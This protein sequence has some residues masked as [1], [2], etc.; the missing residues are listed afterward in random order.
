MTLA[1]EHAL[2][3]PSHATSPA[4]RRWELSIVAPLIGLVLFF[5]AWQ[6]VVIIFGVKEFELPRPT[7]IFRH[8]FSDLGFYERNARTTLWEAT[9]GFLIAL[10]LALTAATVMAHSRFIEQAAL[11]LVVLA[12][13]TPIIA[14][15]PAVIIWVGYGLEPILVITSFVCFV[16][17]VLNAVTGLRAVDPAALEL[18]RSVKASK[19]EEFF[20]L[21]VPHALPYLFSAARI[22]V[23]LALTGAVLGEFF[24]AGNG[25]LGYAIKV[26]QNH[27]LVL[28]LWGSTFV[29]G[30]LGA[31]AVLGLSGLERVVLRWHHSQL[32]DR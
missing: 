9:L 16:P 24:A 13:V 14:Y 32:S 17:F 26:A 1:S 27:S 10:V 22:A 30:F 18:M 20:V 25:G 8:I 15:V 12:Q 7:A 2:T 29:L 23:G 4:K 3:E 31:I 6:L 5:L 19:R 11:P 21:R 28:Q